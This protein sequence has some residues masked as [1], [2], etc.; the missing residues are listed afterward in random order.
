M[1]LAT[2]RLR[3]D[4]VHMVHAALIFKHAG[5]DACL[6]KCCLPRRRW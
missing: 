6:E 4:P 3:L 5:V 2:D 1:D